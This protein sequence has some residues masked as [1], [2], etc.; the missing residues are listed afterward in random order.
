MDLTESV[1]LIVVGWLLGTLS[2]TIIGAIQKERRRSEVLAAMAVELREVRYK[3]ALV[4]LRVKRSLAAVDQNTLAIVKPLLNHP[5]TPGDFDLGG[6][7]A[8]L[9]KNGDELYIAMSNANGQEKNPPT[10]YPRQRAL[11]LEAHVNELSG[12]TAEHQRRLLK[13]LDELALFNN[14]VEFLRRLH[15]LSFTLTGTNH[16][17]NSQNTLIAHEALGVRAEYLVTSINGVIDARGKQLKV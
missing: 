9:L 13:V 14:Q 3:S 16:A 6:S 17:A 2:P 7:I 12:L 10:W 8:A 5:T 11:Y 15:E 1:A 4:L